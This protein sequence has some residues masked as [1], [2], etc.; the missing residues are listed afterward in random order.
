MRRAARSR[1]NM[2]Q[3]RVRGSRMIPRV[4]RS[5]VLNMGGP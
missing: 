4:M 1:M 2:A 5:I 3:R